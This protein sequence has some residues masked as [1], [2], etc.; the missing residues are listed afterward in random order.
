[1]AGL[2]AGGQRYIREIKCRQVEVAMPYEDI[3]TLAELTG[4]KPAQ[5]MQLFK[6]NG[7]TTVFLKE[8][9]LEERKDNAEIMEID[10][11]TPFI[12]AE[13][14]FLTAQGLQQIIEQEGPCAS[15][16]KELA[17]VSPYNTGVY[18]VTR[19]QD[20]LLQ[21]AGQL[22]AKTKVARTFFLKDG[23]L[24]VYTPA[25]YATLRGMGLGFSQTT[26]QE[27]ARAGLLTAIQLKSWPDA[28][29][30]GL[31]A[32]FTPLKKIPHLSALFFNDEIL[33]AYPAYIKS[34]AALIADLKVPVGQI[35]FFSQK[36][37]TKL[38]ILLDK[39]VVRLHS[40]SPKEMA[41]PNYTFTQA[42]DRYALAAAERNVRFLLVRPFLRSDNGGAGD[43]ILTA[44]LNFYA[45]LKQAL[46]N[47]KLRLGQA[48]VF[49]SLPVVRWLLFLMGLG[50]I[51]GGLLL[52][53]KI[54][55]PRRT[56][57][58][59]GVLTVL[60]WLFLLY[61]NL[62]FGRKAMALAAVIIFPVLSLLIN[63]PS[64]GVSPLESVWRLIRTSLMSLP[65]AI[66]TVGLLADTGYMLKL[67][68][69]SGVKAAHLLPLLILIVVFYFCFISSPVPG[70][71][72]LKKLFDAALPVKWA[73]IGLILLSLG[74]VYILRTG[75]ET[76]LI[77]SSLELK[78]RT[79]L[80]LVLGVRPR[81]KEFLLG[82]PL[83]L[84]LFYTGYRDHRFLPLLLLGAIGQVSLI[85]TYAHIHTPLLISLQRSFNGLWLGI[86]I[87]LGLILI[88]Y[89]VRQWG[90]KYF[91]KERNSFI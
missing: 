19:R 68:M 91:T 58:I 4:K 29:P 14:A 88:F 53:E 74:V 20:T 37:L 21:L 34:L 46:E 61:F 80:D 44:N 18:F 62:N 22:K 39:K 35:E 16:L 49:S 82:H 81:T 38:G 48:S 64:Q 83:L 3:K 1:M 40:I 36:G 6:Q 84:L 12:T 66:L 27:I 90:Q 5:V 51:A 67:D 87:G 56:G 24:A 17:A 8:A 89:F 70:G 65:G 86:L 26:L 11:S 52:W 54:K 25:S 28:T 32:V 42:K 73:I 30:E 33:P 57:I 77:S 45:G 75:N 7:L 79:L 76:V 31:R 59:L 23:Y 9:T 2:Y 69:F 15:W 50:V 47:E 63:V 60:G 10:S 41:N 78:A 85:N 72:R 13:F 43:R 55:L 71:L